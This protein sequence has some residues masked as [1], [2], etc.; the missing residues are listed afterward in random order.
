MRIRM[1]SVRSSD[2]DTLQR[3]LVLAKRGMATVQEMVA[4][5]RE[6]G[7][8]MTAAD[9]TAGDGDVQQVLA[10]TERGMNSVQEMVAL[11]RDTGREMRLLATRVRQLELLAFTDPLTGLLNRRGFDYAVAREEARAR[12]FGCLVALA[13]IDVHGLK[14]INDRHGHIAGDTVLRTVGTAL[15]TSARGSDI[16]ARF[17]GDEFVALL[18]GTDLA[19]VRV[20]LQRARL[21]ARVAELPDGT[22]IGIDFAAGI[23]SRDEAGS[24]AAA[25]ETADQRLLMEKQRARV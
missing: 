23:A 16:V 15:A 8:H 7:R 4:V 17:G 18:L 5:L 13:L 20:F 14:T 6:S 2:D 24:I 19:G 10:T 25:F 12:R 21:A 11:L 1:E 3:L 22:T 9:G